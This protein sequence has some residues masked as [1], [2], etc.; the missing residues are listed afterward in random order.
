MSSAIDER[1]IAPLWPH[2]DEREQRRLHFLAYLRRSGRLR[3]APA[4]SPATEALCAA[5]LCAVRA[6]G[7]GSH[8]A[9]HASPALPMGCRRCGAPG[10]RS[11]APRATDAPPGGRAG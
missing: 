10:P 2:L 7:Q 11:S 1:A 6:A 3:P 5:L 9:Y 4:V 8:P